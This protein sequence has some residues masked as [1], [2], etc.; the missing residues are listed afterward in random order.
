MS[1]MLSHWDLNKRPRDLEPSVTDLDTSLTG[2]YCKKILKF[3][4]RLYEDVVNTE[5][6][7]L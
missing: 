3:F 4:G 6:G 5:V 7:F 2:L 1:N